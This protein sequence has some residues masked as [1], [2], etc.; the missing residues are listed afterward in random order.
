MKVRL[1]SKTIKAK[2]LIKQHGPVWRVLQEADSLLFSDKR[3]W[4]L[5]SP[6]NGTD[7]VLSR[8]VHKTDDFNFGVTI[9]E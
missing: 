8:W 6:L 3:G 4:L 9:Q 5:V 7:A 1:T 2:T